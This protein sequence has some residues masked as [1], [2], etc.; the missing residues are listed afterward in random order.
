MMAANAVE[1][2]RQ[3]EL[4]KN[5]NPLCPCLQLRDAS[6]AKETLYLEGKK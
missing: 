2:S 5:G 3:V 1:K 4:R 6:A